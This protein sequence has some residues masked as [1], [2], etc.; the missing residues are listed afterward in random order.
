M[1]NL[2]G[3][4]FACTCSSLGTQCNKAGASLASRWRGASF[5]SFRRCLSSRSQFGFK[6]LLGIFNL[7]SSLHVHLCLF[8]AVAL[9]PRMLLNF[10]FH[11][12]SEPVCLL[13]DA[14]SR[15]TFVA[16]YALSPAKHSCAGQLP[17]KSQWPQTWPRLGHLPGQKDIIRFQLPACSSIAFRRSS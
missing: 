17:G 9:R 7:T 10:C 11:P 8:N 2:L 5:Y 16:S 1:P 6:G 13:A 14:A 12:G 4:G 15:E 3:F